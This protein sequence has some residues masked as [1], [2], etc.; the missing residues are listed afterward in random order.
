MFALLLAAV[1]PYALTLVPKAQI[2]FPGSP[3]QI[4]SGPAN[5]DQTV[6]DYPWTLDQILYAPNRSAAA[7]RFCWDIGKYGGCET[8]VA[9]PG[10]PVLKLAKGDVSQLLWTA[11]GKYLIGAGANTLRLWN[12]VGGVRT[13]ATQPAGSVV[14]RLWL[15]KSRLGEADLC[16]SVA[17]STPLNGAYVAAMTT[18]RHSLPTL[19]VLTLT[20][21]PT[22]SSQQKAKEAECRPFS[23]S[24]LN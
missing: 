6:V 24:S 14:Q 23:S 8:S 19:K 17:V 3:P 20:T 4:I 2:T 13:V 22:A 9:R 18:I 7:V 16:V 11:D 21:L 5:T 15:S 12:L 1:S 10:Q